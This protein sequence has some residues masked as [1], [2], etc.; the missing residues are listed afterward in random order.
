MFLLTILD[1]VVL[2]CNE[3]KTDIYN[4]IIVNAVALLIN[5]SNRQTLHL[6]MEKSLLKLILNEKHIH[7]TFVGVDIW[8]LYFQ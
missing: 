1:D 2:F 3:T 6:N 7:R 4:N 5:I 8:N